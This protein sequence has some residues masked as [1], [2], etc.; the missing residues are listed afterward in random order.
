M[1]LNVGLGRIYGRLTDLAHHGVTSAKLDFL[2]F[3]ASDFENL[4]K[5]FETTMQRALIRPL[6]VHRTIDQFLSGD[7]PQ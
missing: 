1:F 3:S 6:D 2:N 7:P 4:M 5:D